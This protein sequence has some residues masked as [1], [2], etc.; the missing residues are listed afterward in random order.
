MKLFHLCLAS[1]V[2]ASAPL[3]AQNVHVIDV[4]GRAKPKR[5]SAPREPTERRPR[6]REGENI[7]VTLE[8]EPGDSVLV[9]F[10]SLPALRRNLAVLDG[11]ILL[12]FPLVNVSLGDLP[13]SGPQTIGAP[14]GDLGPGVSTVA[15]FISASGQLVV[16]EPTA[17]T[18]L[19]AG[20]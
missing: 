14:I 15:L 16:S 13:A 3:A 2:S 7:Q 6:L 4:A 10:S 18:L 20:Y 11:P 12:S 5:W 19:D 17:E 8:G 1:V 9:F